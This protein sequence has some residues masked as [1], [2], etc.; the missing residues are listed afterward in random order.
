[1]W[2]I[3]PTL[4]LWPVFSTHVD[5]EVVYLTVMFSFKKNSLLKIEPWHSS[6]FV[7][8]RFVISRPPPPSFLSFTFRFFPGSLGYPSS[9]FNF[10]AHRNFRKHLRMVGSRRIKA[11]SESDVSECVCVCVCLFVC[12]YIWLW[13][14]SHPLSSVFILFLHSFLVSGVFFLHGTERCCFA[15]TEGDTLLHFPWGLHVY[16]C[17]L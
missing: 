2:N 11:Q 13:C 9:T 14:C 3:T 8:S 5:V 7:S 15:G 1:M 6:L 4:L 16:Q 10:S 12:C 17:V